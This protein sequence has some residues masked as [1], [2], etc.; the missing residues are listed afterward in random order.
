M[1]VLSYSFVSLL[2]LELQAEILAGTLPPEE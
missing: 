1:T 2:D